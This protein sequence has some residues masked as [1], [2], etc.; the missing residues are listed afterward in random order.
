MILRLMDRRLGRKGERERD[1]KKGRD[2]VGMLGLKGE[3]MN[4]TRLI[5][6]DSILIR[7]RKGLGWDTGKKR[8]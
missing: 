2:E 6:N 8:G 3:R 5:L 7:G 4:E 1:A